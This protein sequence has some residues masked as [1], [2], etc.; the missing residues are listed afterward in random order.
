M[1][2]QASSFFHLFLGIILI[3]TLIFC[4]N[5]CGGGKKK[6]SPSPHV[7]E[8]PSQNVDAAVNAEDEQAGEESEKPVKKTKKKKSAKNVSEDGETEG[9]AAEVKEKSLPENVADWTRE[10]F[11]LAK[12]Q[13]VKDSSYSL[14]DAITVLGVRNAGTKKADEDAEILAELMRKEFPPDFEA[15]IAAAEEAKKKAEAEKA[16]GS[17]KKSKKNSKKTSDDSDEDENGPRED[18]DETSRENEIPVY[19]PPMDFM[20]VG[21][22]AE[23]I[24][25]AVSALLENKSKTAKNVMTDIFRRN[26][27]TD[28]DR[29]A[30]QAF[31]ERL[32][33]ENTPENEN[34]L[35]RVLTSAEEL[36]SVMSEQEKAAINDRLGSGKELKNAEG[37]RVYLRTV[38]GAG[39]W[40]DVTPREMRDLVMN[41]VQ[42]NASAAFRVKTA[43]Y[44]M[45][46]KSETTA[47]NEVEMQRFA[48]TLLRF[49]MEKKPENKEA[50]LALYQDSASDADL[51]SKLEENLLPLMQ[52]T[53]RAEFLLV[54]AKTLED[55]QKAVREMKA[56]KSD[57][58]ENTSS[59]KKSSAAKS[60]LSGLGTE[61]NAPKEP[62]SGRNAASGAGEYPLPVQLLLDETLLAEYTEKFWSD[63]QLE[64][65]L[66][67]F[68]EESAS[69]L[70]RF[71]KGAE[72]ADALNAISGRS[73][74]MLMLTPRGKP[75][76]LFYDIFK[77]GW[78]F[79]PA[80]V[81][82]VGLLEKYET[83][84]GF[85]MIVK[86]LERKDP[87]KEKP[88]TGRGPVGPPTKKEL[89]QKIAGDWMKSCDSLVR[90]WCEAFSL[91]GETQAAITGKTVTEVP[92]DFAV[93]LPPEA[94]IVSFYSKNL[95][96]KAD[97]AGDSLKI[98]FV[99]LKCS[100]RWST[101][102]G[103]CKRNLKGIVQ[104]D[105]ETSENS[106]LTELWLERFEINEKTKMQESLDVRI[107]LAGKENIDLKS[108]SQVEMQIDI[109]VMEMEN[110]EGEK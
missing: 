14:K 46:P 77:K 52:E 26:L 92:K 10:D 91:A 20:L 102:L 27:M 51:K 55:F 110:L 59:S 24:K 93:P 36:R 34:F 82:R 2:I 3:F 106:R 101:I 11:L 22:S 86:S 78:E 28:D 56:E 7:E 57:G 12:K 41:Q 6:P 75:R 53:M 105:L 72:M 44:L 9:E 18:N 85:L 81:A 13:K 47:E 25:T 65:E 74:Q 97:E 43:K 107:S 61:K 71:A 88:K 39:N 50:Q 31:I 29:T 60:L 33:A 103:F 79:G 89:R 30:I 84:P 35:F 87:V 73:V 58:N 16:A 80:G 19:L 54:D 76:R 48:E 62:K 63:A 32:A 8:N 1:K 40:T 67:R 96:S 104:H 83:E 42:K 4:G 21:L 45:D 94:K 17:K 98:S 49:L 99:R 38:G 64:T 15:E 70:K 69:V 100:S 95:T 90:K 66:A 68:Q 109:L 23:E 108:N 5:G 37:R